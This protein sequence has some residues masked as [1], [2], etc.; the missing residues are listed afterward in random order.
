MQE[1]E[2]LAH[3]KYGFV[4]NTNTSVDLYGKIDGSAIAVKFNMINGYFDCAGNNLTSL[5]GCPEEVKGDFMCSENM[6]TSLEYG[7]GIVEGNYFCQLNTLTTLKGAPCHSNSLTSL[8]YG[9]KSV[10]AMSVALIIC[11]L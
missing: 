3:G 10:R 9:P 5:M 4:V 6:L 7:P 11:R 8:E 2:L 1:Y